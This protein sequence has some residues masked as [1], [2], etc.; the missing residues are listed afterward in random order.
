MFQH[1]LCPIDGSDASTEALDLAARFAAD[2]KAR[3]TICMVVDPAKAAA[4]AYG[5]PGM[6]AACFDA[7]DDEA[8]CVLDEAVARVK[9]IA[10]ADGMVLDG[11]TTSSIVEFCTTNLC[12]LIVMGSHGR[13]GIQRAILGSVAEGV[14][15]HSNVP[16]LIVRHGGHSSNGA[17]VM[18]KRVLCPIDGSERW[19]Q[20]LDVAARLAADQDAHLTICTVVDPDE[21]I[22]APDPAQGLSVLKREAQVMLDDA[23]ARVKAILAADTVVLVGRPA[24][25]IV[26]FAN[27]T[28]DVIVMGSHGR[29]GIMR[30]ILGSV[31]EGVVRHAN[32]PAMLV[33]SAAAPATT[34]VASADSQAA[35]A[36]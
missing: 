23:A 11:P 20:A 36:Q 30:A 29:S 14:L 33:R 32:V 26:Q 1:I 25:E 28:C 34:T 31:A 12:D 27:R 10:P 5:D 35:T 21:A 9:N 18:I 3:L 22:E 2:Q 19:M 6:S 4:M 15:R 7:L 17:V 16:V 13:G 8:K 24:D